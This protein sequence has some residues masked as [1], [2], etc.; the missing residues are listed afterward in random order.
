LVQAE[1]VVED[2]GEESTNSGSADKKKKKKVN[3]M[4]S[5]EKNKLKK[6]KKARKSKLESCLIMTRS[7]Y[8][9]HEDTFTKYLD[10]HPAT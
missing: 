4:S 5:E 7:Y 1:T 10:E 2:L 8:K 3:N 6:I 9:L